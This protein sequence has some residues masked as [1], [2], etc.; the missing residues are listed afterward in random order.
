MKH[1]TIYVI[2]IAVVIGLIFY[3]DISSRKT[4]EAKNK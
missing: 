3:F 2:L 4:E 1:T